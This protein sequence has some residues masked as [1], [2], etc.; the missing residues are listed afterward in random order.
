MQDFEERLKRLEEI[1]ERLRSGELSID[2][3]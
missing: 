2:D 1:G 3:A